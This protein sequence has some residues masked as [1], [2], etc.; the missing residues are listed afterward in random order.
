MP[1]VDL[2]EDDKGGHELI[3][4]A[5]TALNTDGGIL[6]HSEGVEGAA[7]PIVM[8]NSLRMPTHR[9]ETIKGANVIKDARVP[10]V[11][12]GGTRNED[13]GEAIKNANRGTLAGCG[14]GYLGG[15]GCYLCDSDHP[16]R[17]AGGAV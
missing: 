15:K 8:P 11:E 9:K 7:Y 5:K 4:D 17:K 3:K 16:Y 10:R 6:N 14:H 13:G 2:V 12:E 1:M